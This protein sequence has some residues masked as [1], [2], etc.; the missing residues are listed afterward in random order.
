M[1]CSIPIFEND[2]FTSAHIRAQRG[3]PSQ[4][5]KIL[6]FLVCRSRT[7]SRHRGRNGREWSNRSQFLDSFAGISGWESLSLFGRIFGKPDSLRCI[8]LVSLFDI[9]GPALSTGGCASHD[10]ER[11][12]WREMTASHVAHHYIF[13]PCFSFQT[14]TSTSLL[15][16]V[17]LVEAS[18]PLTL[19]KHA[20]ISN[21]Y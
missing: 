15:L 4:A 8:L 1:S 2:V 20:S 5:D 13:P 18:G 9:S 7:S 12:W 10:R 6:A 14:C 11:W 19:T 21:R 16:S 17:Y 3:F